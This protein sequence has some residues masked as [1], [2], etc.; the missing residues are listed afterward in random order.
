MCFYFFFCVKHDNVDD[1]VVS[2]TINMNTHNNTEQKTKHFN[3]IHMGQMPWCVSI[4]EYNKN[5]PKT[6][7]TVYQVNGMGEP[8]KTQ[9]II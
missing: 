5:S 6:I 7:Q 8:H 3:Q 4:F 9:K 1:D 2:A